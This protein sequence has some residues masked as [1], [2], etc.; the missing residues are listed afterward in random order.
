VK[1]NGARP[2]AAPRF[3]CPRLSSGWT[4]IELVVVLA[5]LA[6]ITYFGVR[7]F[8]PKEAIA[9]QQAERLRNDLRHVQM[10]A[11]TW[12]RPLRLTAAATSYQVCCLDA[13][14]TA[15][16]P[17]PPVPPGP[18]TVPDPVVDPATGRPFLVALE[19][20]L[21]L[22]LATLDFDALGRPW[23]GGAPLPGPGPATFN[24]NGASAARTVLVA[25]LTGFATA[26]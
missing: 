22:G 6:I 19:S 7:S 4:L 24:I 18:C 14:M 12:G 8:Q 9:L 13:A 23:N 21:T 2:L 11:L 26:Q 10:L 20:G 3:F 5:V 25:P 16:L 15:C 17:T 1:P